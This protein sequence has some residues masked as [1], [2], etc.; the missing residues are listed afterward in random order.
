MGHRSFRSGC[1]SITP[2]RCCVAPAQRGLAIPSTS[3]NPSRF[4]LQFSTPRTVL[5]MLIA[6]VLGTGCTSTRPAPDARPSDQSA[7]RTDAGTVEPRLRAEA[8][9][10]DGVPHR[11]GG[12]DRR[13]VDCSG[14]TQALYA[15]VLDLRLPRDTRRQSRVGTE[16]RRSQLQPGDLVFFRP[17]RKDRHVGVYLSNGE[18]VHA[19][20]SSGVTVSSLDDRYWKRTWWQAR[21]VL[22]DVSTSSSPAPEESA[23]GEPVRGGW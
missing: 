4:M 9:R 6:V 23:P 16:V 7:A 10:W 3:T 2:R 14:L 18:F 13:G 5:L 15:D 19:S 1:R 11:L 22:Q 17:S 20:A 12:T 21:R 8:R